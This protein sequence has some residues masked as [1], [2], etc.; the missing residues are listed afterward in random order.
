MEY[1][2]KVVTFEQLIAACLLIYGKEISSKVMLKVLALFT[3]ELG[4]EYTLQDGP[5]SHIEEY[6]NYDG[7][8]IK[9]KEEF[10][11]LTV[12]KDDFTIKNKLA[13][14]AGNDA[15]GYIDF[16]CSKGCLNCTNPTCKVPSC[17]KSGIDEIGF[18]EGNEC[19]GWEN[20]QYKQKI[21]T[22]G[23]RQYLYK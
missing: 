23:E 19:I 22:Y 15:L 16:L 2:Q 6:I 14:L 10:N 1:E 5:L 20:R 11:L 7:Q 12:I 4:N 18:P 21:L 17:E 3:K 13:I 8:N 9:L